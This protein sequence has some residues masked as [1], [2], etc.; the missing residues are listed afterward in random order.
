M[1]KLL[2]MRDTLRIDKGVD[3]EK[4][5]PRTIDSGGGAVKLEG[6]SAM[7]DLNIE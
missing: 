5:D 4:S 1:L 2:E 7:L 6:L 3:V